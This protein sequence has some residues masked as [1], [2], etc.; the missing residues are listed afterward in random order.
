MSF[1]LHLR[2]KLLEKN[3]GKMENYGTSE[4]LKFLKDFHRTKNMGNLRN[5]HRKLKAVG[6]EE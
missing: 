2:D 4:M 3:K 5:K 6:T 1:L